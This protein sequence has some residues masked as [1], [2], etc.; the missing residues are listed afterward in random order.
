MLGALSYDFSGLFDSAAPKKKKKPVDPSPTKP[1]TPPAPVK[2]PSW[3]PTW[4]PLVIGGIGLL[5]VV[6]LLVTSKGKD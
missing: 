6:G 1:V 5:V 4:T 2:S 3:L